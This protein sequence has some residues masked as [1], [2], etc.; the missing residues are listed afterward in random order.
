MSLEARESHPE[1]PPA[2]CWTVIVYFRMDRIIFEN[3]DSV[4]NNVEQLEKLRN[5]IYYR[6]RKM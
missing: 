2:E 5:N 1:D 4:R 6:K 3:V